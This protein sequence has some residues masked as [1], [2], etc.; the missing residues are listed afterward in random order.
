MTGDSDNGEILEAVLA[1]NG[2]RFEELVRQFQKPLYNFILNRVRDMHLAADL[3]QE[4]FFKAYRGLGSF[5]DRRS[6]F[7]TW[8]FRIGLN[9]CH[10]H[11]R[12][13]K[14]KQEGRRAFERDA[15]VADASATTPA[16]RLADRD[17]LLRMLARLDREEADLLLMRFVDDLGYDELTVVTGLGASTLRSRVHRALRKLQDCLDLSNGLEGGGRA[18]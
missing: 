15:L 14:V 8:L 18:V 7:K 11:F 12:R 9:L 4:C 17:Q 1:G 5:D 2:E 16:E 3:T 13:E 6:S 10:D